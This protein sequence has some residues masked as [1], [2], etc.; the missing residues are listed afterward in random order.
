MRLGG[1]PSYATFHARESLVR[2]GYADTPAGLRMTQVYAAL[3]PM[4]T[5]LY[6]WPQQN[7]GLWN[8][9]IPLAQEKKQKRHFFMK[10]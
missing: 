4:C 7:H 6:T 9:F 2:A 8:R 10:S 5:L 3:A 1:S